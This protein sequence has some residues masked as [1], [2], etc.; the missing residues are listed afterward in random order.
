SILTQKATSAYN[1]GDYARALTLLD[2]RAQFAAE[3]NDLLTLRAWSYYH[4]RRFAE[5]KR[6]FQAVVDTGYGEAVGGLQAA[7]GALLA[8]QQ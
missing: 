2:Q 6:I 8:A 5:A 7:T 1:I 3:R 4:L